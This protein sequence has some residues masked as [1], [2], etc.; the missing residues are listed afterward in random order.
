[1]CNGVVML[2]GFQLSTRGGI[3]LMADTVVVVVV[4]GG[5]TS[6]GVPDVVMVIA[7]ARWQSA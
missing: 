1:M 4:A 3:T 5:G 6:G 7:V 2:A